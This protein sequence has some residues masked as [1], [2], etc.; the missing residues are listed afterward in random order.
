MVGLLS[1]TIA[2][3][4]DRPAITR[5]GTPAAHML[6]HTVLRR[7]W[8]THTYVGVDNETHHHEDHQVDRGNQ[9]GANRASDSRGRKGAQMSEYHNDRSYGRDDYGSHC[10]HCNTFIE[11]DGIEFCS[12]DCEREYQA[13]ADEAL[14]NELERRTQT[15]K[16]GNHGSKE[17]RSGNH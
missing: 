11:E 7:A 9:K 15:M 3:N 2:Q 14:A 10:R 6:P 17:N 13:H 16:A 12:Y 8:Q 1:S 5:A 4:G